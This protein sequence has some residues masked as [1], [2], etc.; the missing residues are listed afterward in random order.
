MHRDFAC[1]DVIIGYLDPLRSKVPAEADHLLIQE[2]P[3]ERSIIEK[4]AKLV[5]GVPS[6]NLFRCQIRYETTAEET[7]QTKVLTG[8]KDSQPDGL[9]ADAETLAVSRNPVVQ[10]RGAFLLVNSVQRN[11]AGKYPLKK[12]DE[13]E[14]FAILDG[15]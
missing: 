3:A 4:M 10:L 9:G 13:D 7:L 1:H 11:D 14:L 12:Y 15:A 2:F 8:S 6:K 5:K